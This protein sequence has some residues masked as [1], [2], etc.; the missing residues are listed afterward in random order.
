MPGALSRDAGGGR[1]QVV[2]HFWP[3]MGQKVS[4]RGGVQA[5]PEAR[6]KSSSWL[7]PLKQF[8]QGREI[9]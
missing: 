9:I 6:K 3:G 4:A 2:V 1:D 8:L 7:L 5:W